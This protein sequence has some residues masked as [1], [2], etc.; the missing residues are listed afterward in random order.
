[1]VSICTD[2]C[3]FALL[4]DV[5]KRIVDTFPDLGHTNSS[6]FSRSVSILDSFAR[7]RCCVLCED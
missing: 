7:V 2:L 5:L 4:Q 1:M 3:Y 6:S